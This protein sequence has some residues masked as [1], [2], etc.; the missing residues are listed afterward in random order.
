MCLDLLDETAPQSMNMNF[1]KLNEVTSF[2]SLVSERYGSNFYS[3]IFKLISRIYIFG[4]SNKITL[5]WMPQDFNSD[6]STMAQ[7]MVWSH[8]TKSHYV[9][10]HWPSSVM[11]YG[12]TRLQRVKDLPLGLKELSHFMFNNML[13]LYLESNGKIIFR[14]GLKISTN[15]P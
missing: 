13:S 6:W 7:V 4:I 5:R 2:N 3:I 1:F 9:N 11:P 8:Q 15:S 14:S 12:T 10:Q